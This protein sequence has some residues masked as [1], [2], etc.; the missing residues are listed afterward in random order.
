MVGEEGVERDLKTRTATADD[1]LYQRPDDRDRL[2]E[3]F[4]LSTIHISD[5]YNDKAINAS[6]LGLA[7]F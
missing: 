4:Y 3:R 1:S 2:E 5:G 6:V 7:S